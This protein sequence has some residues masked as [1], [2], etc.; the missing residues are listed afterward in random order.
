M[1]GGAVT[2][3]MKALKDEFIP[4]L[5][6]GTDM[7][8]FSV[9]LSLTRKRWGN[10]P[11]VLYFHENQLTYPWS[12]TDADK[13][14]RDH[15]Y[16]YIN[17]T[18]ALS[19]DAILFNSH[20]HRNSFLTALPA[21]L[22][23]FPDFQN[24]ECA[25]HLNQNSRVLPLGMDLKTLAALPRNKAEKPVILWTHRW[26]YD[27]NPDG[28]FRVLKTLADQGFDFDLI[29]LGKEYPKVPPI[30]KQAKAWFSDR[31]RHWGYAES[32]EQ[33]HQ[34][35]S[36]ATL[37][38]VTS[39]QDFFGLSVIEGIAAGCVPLLPNRLAYPEHIP[40][41]LQDQFL[42][43]GED[44]LTTKLAQWLQNP[45]DASQLQKILV[46]RYDWST[47]APK[48]DTILVELAEN[49]LG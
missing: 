18:S 17:F 47:M 41:E 12:E 48:Y 38:P 45:P 13:G 37:R 7:M 1:H 23:Q 15:H 34:L 42:Y 9:F 5:N 20:Y 33:Y 2:L 32:L 14:K 28:F 10:I 43:S 3:A 35:L 39:N 29:V 30:F 8:D 31:I 24:G 11:A 44:A 26:E 49:H 21:F 36:E 19:A 25:E 22:Q 46:N 6:I 27:K 4:D 16:A 40:E